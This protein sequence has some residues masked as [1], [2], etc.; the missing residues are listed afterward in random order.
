M[1]Q[2][3]VEGILLLLWIVCALICFTCGDKVL[4]TYIVISLCIFIYMHWND[5]KL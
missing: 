2:E 4:V 5:I 1:L 3:I